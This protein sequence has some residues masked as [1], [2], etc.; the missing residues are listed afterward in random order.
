MFIET[1]IA[2][3]LI[4]AVLVLFHEFGHFAAARLVGMR[5]EEFAFGFGPKMITLFKRG[6]TE[7]TLH[8]IP[9]GGFCKIAGMEPDE[10]D[11]PDG[12]QAQAIW[13]R[14]LVIFAGPFMSFVLAVLVFVS[15]GVYWG[16]P[17]FAKVQ[18]R[19]GAVNPQTEA[20]RMNLRAGDRILEINGARVTDGEQLTS[21]IHSRP[22]ERIN[23]VIDRAAGPSGRAGL[24]GG[25]CSTSGRTGHLWAKGARS[26]R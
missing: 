26:M 13:K 4:F 1:A 6:D 22:G 20:Y 25:R 8:P 18:N 15:L 2:L 12:F 9:L 14:A 16:F 17:D 5:V 21:F 7:Y 11:I 24:L 19:V 10:Q 23:L 3:V